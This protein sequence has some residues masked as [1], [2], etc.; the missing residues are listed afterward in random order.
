MK[1]KVDHDLHIHSYLSSCSN[2]PEQNPERILKYAKENG[3]NTVCLTD[4]FWDETVRGASSWYKP[5]NYEHISLAKPLPQDDNVKFLFGCETEM[6]RFNTIGLS[7]ARMD[8]FD[9][10]VIP[11]THFH[12]KG[13]TVSFKDLMTTQGRVKAWVDRLDYVLS[14]DLPFDKVGIAHLTC[15]T[16]GSA[17]KKYLD[18]IDS[19]PVADMERLFEKAAILGVGIELN[20]DDLEFSDE[21]EE[22][23]LKPYKIAK[24]CGCKFYCGSDAHRPERLDAAKP[25]F[26]RAIDKLELEEND[27]ISFLTNQ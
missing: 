20:S 22:I 23:V 27:K 7:K 14:M 12:M 24:E 18:I 1:F 2:N 8:A 4:H 19:I 9:F 11:T 16:I 25:I 13:F 10:I 3:L 17:K 6:N 21:E 26:E 15:S 5:Q